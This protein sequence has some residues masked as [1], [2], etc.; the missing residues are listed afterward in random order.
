[1]SYLY[2]DESEYWD[3]IEDE[4]EGS[5]MFG[6]MLEAQ[7]VH[8]REPNQCCQ[9]GKLDEALRQKQT[10]ERYCSEECNQKWHQLFEVRLRIGERDLAIRGYD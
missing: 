4:L 7:L 9:C 1:M 10:S 8:F 2:D 5:G 6:S 3:D